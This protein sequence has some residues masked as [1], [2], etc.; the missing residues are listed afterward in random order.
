[1]HLAESRQLHPSKCRSYFGGVRYFLA[2]QSIDTSELET[3][4]YWRKYKLGA[5]NMFRV[6]APIADAKKLTLSCDMFL[7]GMRHVF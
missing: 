7:F 3:S 6:R 4:V 5:A 2:R 1:M